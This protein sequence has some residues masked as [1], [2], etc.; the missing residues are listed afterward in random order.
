[1]PTRCTLAW[2]CLPVLE[3]D[4]STILQGRDWKIEQKKKKQNLHTGHNI[5]YNVQIWPRNTKCQKL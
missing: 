5:K 2:P 3:V 1:M 4:I